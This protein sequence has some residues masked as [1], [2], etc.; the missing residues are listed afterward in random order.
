MRIRLFSW[1]TLAVLAALLVS[2]GEDTPAPVVEIF[3]EADESDPYTIY[4]TTVSSNA[5]TFSWEFGDDEVG[6]GETPS[7]TYAMSGD[8]TVTLTATGD[9][10][11]SMATKEV[12]IAASL[13]EMLSGGPL[14]TNG[15]TWILSRT[16]TPGVDGAGTFDPDFPANMM[17]GT[18]NV[19]EIIGLGAEYDNEYTF[20]HDG[21]YAVD[22]VD[23]A[24]L[25]SW[26][27]ASLNVPQEDWV[28]TTDYGIFSVKIQ[29]P[30]NA[31][32]SLTEDTDLTVDA[33]DELDEGAFSPKTVT[34]ENADYLTFT[35][36]GYIGLQD[37]AIHAIIRQAESDRLTISV[38]MHSVLD[39]SDKP[40]H[41]LTLSFDEK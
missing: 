27:Y 1:I 20:Y 16:A 23:G 24:N 8:Y 2:C 25:V 33:V 38:F 32:W 3:F 28:T 29:E 22:N 19:L 12:T 4:F 41:I 30:E 7:H 21:S 11:E 34:F 36:G 18:D 9:G 31:G 26:V 13:A 14:A 40:S 37:Q 39:A 15:K 35:N 17:P 6:S 5:S 10:G